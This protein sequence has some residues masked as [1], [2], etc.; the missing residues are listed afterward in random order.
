MIGGDALRSQSGNLIVTFTKRLGKSETFE[1]GKSVPMFM[2]I[3]AGG[4]Q[5]SIAVTR[6]CGA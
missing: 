6:S 3:Y 2:N 4:G 1:E 5:R